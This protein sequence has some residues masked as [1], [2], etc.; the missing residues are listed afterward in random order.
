MVEKLIFRNDEVI[1]TYIENKLII[2]KASNNNLLSVFLFGILSLL[3]TNTAFLSLFS[4]NYVQFLFFT[5]AII[6]LI[7]RFLWEFRGFEIVE[8]DNNYLYTKKK[9][10]FFMFESK[11][12]LA[13]VKNLKHKIEHYK[14]PL[15]HELDIS[16]IINFYFKIIGMESGD[17][18]FKYGYQTVSF[19]HNLSLA[20]KIK[21]VDEINKRHKFH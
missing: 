19:F 2:K 15:N 14:D 1:I 8:I 16:E 21:I 7:R 4:K 5:L 9:G 12:N 18:L 3:I 10:S 6:W 20:E 17:I 11:Y 13:K